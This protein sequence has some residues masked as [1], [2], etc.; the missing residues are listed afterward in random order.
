MEVLPFLVA[1]LLLA[2]L[3]AYSFTNH[4]APGAFRFGLVMLANIWWMLCYAMDL[5]A[6]DV[7]STTFWLQVKY[8][9][10]L[11]SAFLWLSLTL[12]LTGFN[13]MLKSR[14]YMS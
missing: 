12:E 8:F 4:R 1:S 14:W 2:V 6:T 3:A 10:S 11:G 13:S 9:G 5:I 7:E